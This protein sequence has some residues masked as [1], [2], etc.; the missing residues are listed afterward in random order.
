MFVAEIG[1]Y[2]NKTTTME[3]SEGESDFSCSFQNAVR[4]ALDSKFKEIQNLKPV[5]EEVL[6]KFIQ[7][8]DVFSVLP[9]GSGKSLI[10]QLV[11]IVCSYLHDQG[12]K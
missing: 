12:F 2:V 6:F 3:V 5:Q 9:T 4:Y 1:D 11:P 8:N 7:W 10:F